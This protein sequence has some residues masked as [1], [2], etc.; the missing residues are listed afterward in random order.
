MA[1]NPNFVFTDAVPAQQAV[2]MAQ[3]AAAQDAARQ[4]MMSD[5]LRSITSQ[6]VAKDNA[7]Q[8]RYLTQSQIAQQDKALAQRES[9][10][11]RMAD[12]YKQQA[13]AQTTQTAEKERSA[14]AKMQAETLRN[15]MA[16]SLPSPAKWQKILQN[17]S[18]VFNDDERLNI[19]SEYKAL[20]SQA[21]KNY[22]LSIGIANA[23]QAK[24]DKLKPDDTGGR[25]MEINDAEKRY[26]GL[27]MFNP[28]TGRM[29]SVF[30]QPEMDEEPA[31]TPPPGPPAAV[32]QPAATGGPSISGLFN[33]QAPPGAVQL[34]SFLGWNPTL[35]YG[36]GYN[37]ILQ[38]LSRVSG[39][40]NQPPVAPAPMTSPPA[41][42]PRLP[43]NIPFYPKPIPGGW[44]PY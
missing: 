7:A 9:E 1:I 3:I 22:N 6:Q 31:L 2:S 34:P 12:I 42:P 28:E 30:P 23:I 43:P 17:Q 18:L 4:Q 36:L 20:R 19:D 37:P 16:G 32:V 27:I 13:T 33:P 38:G 8:Q 10:S 14:R 21:E 39:G 29:Q 15:A 26:K 44:E 41:P 40:T 24:L 11:I 5:T 25:Q 35:R